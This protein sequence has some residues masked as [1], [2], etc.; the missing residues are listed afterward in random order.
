MKRYKEK[1]EKTCVVRKILH[2]LQKKFHYMVV[3][4][5]GYWKLHSIFDFSEEQRIWSTGQE[6][7][8]QLD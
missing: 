4:I 8:D 1:M 3:V 6:L 2:S 5:E 7:V